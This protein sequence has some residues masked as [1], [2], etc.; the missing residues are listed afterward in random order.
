MKKSVLIVGGYGVVGRQIAE[1][2]RNQQDDLEIFIGGRNPGKAEGLFEEDSSI[3]AVKIDNLSK[4]PLKE[5][6]RDLTLIINA[7]NDPEHYLL[8]SAVEKHI[9][10]IDITSWTEH[11]KDSIH[12]L[13]KMKLHSPV[14]LSSGWMGGVAALFSRF[15]TASFK[16][17]HLVNINILLSI[18]DKAGPNSI[19][20]MD[21]LSVPFEITENRMQRQVYPLTD[22][23]HVKFPNNF[24]TKCYRIDTP[25]HYT[26]PKTLNADSVNVRIAFNHKFSTY[27]LRFLVATGIWKLI[28]GK[29]FKSL[30][31]SMLYNPGDGD[32]HQIVI[33][34]K[35]LDHDNIKKESTLT[36]SDPLG[37]THLTA[38]G[39]VIQAEKVL[40][41]KTKPLSAKIYFPEE[42]EEGSI[43]SPFINQFFTENGVNITVV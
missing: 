4:D 18:A 25:D 28:S 13:D 17:V 41:E 40:Q 7:V 11:M 20:Y 21:R 16:D 12:M 8:R 31:K 34:A 14:I 33:E 23:A 5:V 1:I 3:H 39:A 9:P 15:T 2:L 22:S 30:R 43:D 42:L 26:L 36:I 6:R 32:A 37:Q 38:L 24:R 19:E 27:S 10:I 29:S 35:G